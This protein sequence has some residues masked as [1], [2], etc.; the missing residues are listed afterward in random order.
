MLLSRRLCR[1]A[2]CCSG[3]A[4]RCVALP[5]M[6]ALWGKEGEA[7]R[8]APGRIGVVCQEEPAESRK[9]RNSNPGS[10]S[11]APTPSSPRPGG[12]HM[13]CRFS[14]HSRLHTK[15]LIHNLDM[16]ARGLFLHQHTS[17][18]TSPIAF[19][20]FSHHYYTHFTLI[21]LCVSHA[22]LGNFCNGHHVV[23]IV[24]G[25]D[26]CRIPFKPKRISS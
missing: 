26:A 9:A 15:I 22:W 25:V 3:L 20:L 17:L 18:H 8:Q 19:T 13:H 10:P 6:G 4:G 1:D 12:L 5:V 11:S 21:F 16:N 14:P 7:W 24:L 23:N 2:G